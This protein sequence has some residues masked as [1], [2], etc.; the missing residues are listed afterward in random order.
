MEV[1]HKILEIPNLVASYE[2]LRD[3]SLRYG[4]C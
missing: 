2:A 3:F 1:N 4:F